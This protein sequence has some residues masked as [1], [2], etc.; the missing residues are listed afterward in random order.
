M[1]RDYYCNVCGK[2]MDDWDASNGLH[3]D[4][5]MGYPSDFDGD[6][7]ELDICVQCLDDLIRRCAISP[8]H[9]DIYKFW[10]NS[11][12]ERPNGADEKSD[13]GDMDGA[14]PHE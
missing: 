4:I 14:W 5:F 6:G 12:G 10:Y 1:A 8:L 3:L 13:P 9:S 11:D 7:V 2:R